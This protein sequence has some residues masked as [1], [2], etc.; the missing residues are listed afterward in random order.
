MAG[1]VQS[2]IVPKRKTHIML[3][4]NLSF[5]AANSYIYSLVKSNLIM[6]D[7]K[8]YRTTS[9]GQ[10]FLLAYDYLVRLLQES[11]SHT[12]ERDQAYGATVCVK[13]LVTQSR[14]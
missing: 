14:F 4:S 2:C 3:K 8:K 6:P 11:S 5:S 13:P 7:K 1:I 9:K 10:E 12:K